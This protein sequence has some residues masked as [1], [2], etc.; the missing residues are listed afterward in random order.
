VQ[1]LGYSVAPRLNALVEHYAPSV[2]VKWTDVAISH[3]LPGGLEMNG[4]ILWMS[5]AMAIVAVGFALT[6]VIREI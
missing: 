4:E 5:A 6:R 2:Q 1:L 3:V